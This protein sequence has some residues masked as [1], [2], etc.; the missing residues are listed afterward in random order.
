M[1]ALAEY[2]V[3]GRWQAVLVVSVAGGLTYLLPPITT[4]L[5]YLAAAALAL[6]TLHVGVLAGLQVML[7]ASLAVLLFYQL[8]GAQ[9]IVMLLLLLVL[10]LWVPCWLAAAVLQQTRNLGHALKAI[11]LFGGCALLAVYGY[12]GD[13]VPWWIERLQ[14]IA[15]MLAENGITLQGFSDEEL[16]KGIAALMTGMLVASLIVGVAGS[17]LLARWWQSTLVRAGAF[18]EEFC[19]LRL[20]SSAGL[21][22]L[23]TM[24]FA[25][26]SS[27]RSSELAAQLAMVML[28]PYLL[29]GLAVIHSLVKQA[30]RGSGWLV[31]VYVLLAF[32]PQAAL[33]VA[34]GGLMDTW[35]DFRGRLQRRSADGN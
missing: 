32:L 17:L 20:G 29:V 11:A 33:L 14:A 16:L 22:T 7:I 2:I 12:F 27:G 4:L 3:R 10:A 5:N 24:L 18:R 31:A 19:S 21:L 30:G 13:P 6:V 15:A 8:L 23:G 35:I 25:Q 9:T 34:G 28:V 26:F 1:K